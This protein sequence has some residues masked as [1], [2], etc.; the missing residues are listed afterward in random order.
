MMR[1]LR[2]GYDCSRNLRVVRIRVQLKCVLWT[3][4]IPEMMGY[5][6]VVGLEQRE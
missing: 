6:G 1:K 2:I 3:I 5:H 4:Q